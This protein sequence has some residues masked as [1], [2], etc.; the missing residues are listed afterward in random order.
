MN[1]GELNS[2]RQAKDDGVWAR[3][4]RGGRRMPVS[5]IGRNSLPLFLK[6]GCSGRR[7]DV[8]GGGKPLRRRAA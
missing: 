3:A 6:S 1:S 5:P 4:A 7:G 8:L 2:I